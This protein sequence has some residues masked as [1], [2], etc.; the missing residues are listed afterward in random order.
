MFKNTF[1]ICV[2][3]LLS[4]IGMAFPFPKIQED[5]AKKR[6]QQSYNEYRKDV[7]DLIWCCLKYDRRKIA[8]IETE[9]LIRIYDF[10]SK[11]IYDSVSHSYISRDMNNYLSKRPKN[12]AISICIKKTDVSW[13]KFENSVEAYNSHILKSNK[14]KAIFGNL[15]SV[16][17]SSQIEIPKK[18]KET[19][20]EIKIKKDLESVLDAIYK[21]RKM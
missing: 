12:D 3:I 17:Y 5:N 10:R 18:P 8:P 1:M 9:N 11:D 2:M 4:I 7:C 19:Q 13:E 20:E 16:H 6:I 15:I 21:Q 14:T